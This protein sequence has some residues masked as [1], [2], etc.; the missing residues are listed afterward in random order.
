ML[1]KE[2]GYIALLFFVIQNIT[3]SFDV[4]LII[5]NYLASFGS[6][7]SDNTPWQEPDAAQQDGGSSVNHLLMVQHLQRL[8][9]GRRTPTNDGLGIRYWAVNG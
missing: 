8:R 5:A 2:E 1:Q 9:C 4:S 6:G 3:W 7:G